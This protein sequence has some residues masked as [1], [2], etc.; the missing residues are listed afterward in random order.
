M[1][2]FRASRVLKPLIQ[3][4]KWTF[5]ASLLALVLGFAILSFLTP[6]LYPQVW[7]NCNAL[8][9]IAQ[10]DFLPKLSL[11]GKNLLVVG[12][13]GLGFLRETG[14]SLLAISSLAVAPRLAE[15]LANIQVCLTVVRSPFSHLGQNIDVLAD[16]AAG[17]AATLMPN[18]QSLFVR[19]PEIGIAA[20]AW[21]PTIGVHLKSIPAS[22]SGVIKNFPNAL[23][24]VKAMFAPLG[25]EIKTAVGNTGQ[26]FRNLPHI[27]KNF[28]VMFP[29]MGEHF[30]TAGSHAATAL[31]GFQDLPKGILATCKH[32]GKNMKE[33]AV[34]GISGTLEGMGENLRCVGGDINATFSHM[35]EPLKQFGESVTE[36]VKSAVERCKSGLANLFRCLNGQSGQ[37][38]N[39]SDVSTVADNAKTV[40]ANAKEHILKLIE[41]IKQLI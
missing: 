11:S 35:A 6:G 21:M 16:I 38:D 13:R 26:M 4:F 1:F 32:S 27:G 18:V 33:V 31:R 41:K 17:H 34:N 28:A 39:T 3:A 5:L 29:H 23:P 15:L 9:T 2:A 14:E 30:V 10:T 24:N 12:G 25:G 22:T 36:T 20:K 40:F 7:K 8:F 37:P 19:I